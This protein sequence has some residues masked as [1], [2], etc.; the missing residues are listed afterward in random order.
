[1]IQFLKDFFFPQLLID[2]ETPK[3]WLRVKK[4]CK[5]KKEKQNIIMKVI[6]D[7]DREMLIDKESI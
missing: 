4:I 6:A 1:M 5:S 2:I 3:L 7:L